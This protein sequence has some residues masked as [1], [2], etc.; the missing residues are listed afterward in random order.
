MS[1]IP[2]PALLSKL[3][4]LFG[5]LL[6]HQTKEVRVSRTSATLQLAYACPYCLQALQCMLLLMASTSHGQMNVFASGV[7]LTGS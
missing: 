6:F 3:S 5:H 4:T 1:G 2:D 7:F